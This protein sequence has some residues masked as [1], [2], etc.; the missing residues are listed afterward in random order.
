MVQQSSQYSSALRL[1]EGPS[2]DYIGLTDAA[3]GAICSSNPFA[4]PANTPNRSDPDV[5]QGLVTAI[6]VSD[7]ALVVAERVRDIADII[8]NTVV[9]VVG[10]GGN[11]QNL[12]CT[13][14]SGIYIAA[15]VIN[16]ALK[17]SFSLLTFC[18][19]TIDGAEIEGS[20]E[21][22]SDIYDQNVDI[23]A[24][25]AAH[26][27]NIDTDLGAHDLNMTAEHAVLSA[28]LATHDTDIK[29]L[30]ADIKDAVDEN[31]ARLKSV[32]AMQRQTI[33]LQL[34]PEGRRV[35]DQTDVLTCL[36][37]ACP[38]VLDCP[39]GECDFPIR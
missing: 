28:Q 35:V 31:T 3:Y 37:D 1:G 13:V 14:T 12:A 6:T 5:N 32:Q 18:D 29:L 27:L 16:E 11:P 38:N 4:S 10:F 9:V 30:L 22:A 24:D 23:D 20:F 36:G 34:T 19:A 25:L 2:L 33:K 8:C 7:A 17:I 15:K 26:D 21:R 39:G